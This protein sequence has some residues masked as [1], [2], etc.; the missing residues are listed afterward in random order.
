M[1]SQQLPVWLSLMI[2]TGFCSM[3]YELALAQLLTGLLGNAMARFATTLGVYIVGMGLG[4][5]SFRAK[6]DERDGR[7]FFFAETSLFLLGLCAP[8][9]FV[10]AYRFSFAVSSDAG[11]QTSIVV[12]L[13][14]VVIFGTGFFSGMELPILS[15]IAARRSE[16][17]DSKVLTADYIGMFLASILF[18]FVLYPLI[19]LIPAFSIATLLNLVAAASTYFLIGGRSRALVSAIVVFFALNLAALV[20]ASSLQDWLSNVYASTT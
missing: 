14:H 1:K 17:G 10:G 20:F 19:G 6:D 9:L 18:P 5:I 13:T 8:L 11:T 15:A 4:S 12:A 16:G 2:V 7:L 3:I